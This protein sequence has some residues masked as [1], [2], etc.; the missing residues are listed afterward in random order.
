[1]NQQNRDYGTQVGDGTISTIKSDNPKAP[2]KKVKANFNG[3]AYEIS[4]WYRNGEYGPFDSFTINDLG[5]V[6]PRNPQQQPQQVSPQ[7]PQQQQPQQQQ[8]PTNQ[9]VQGQQNPYNDNPPF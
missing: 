6:Q 1:M 3:R 5:P 4:I 9:P 8:F 2:Y 7:P